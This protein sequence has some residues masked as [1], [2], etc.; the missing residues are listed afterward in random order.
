[1]CPYRSRFAASRTSF[2]SATSDARIADPTRQVLTQRAQLLPMLLADARIAPPDVKKAKT[3]KYGI[4]VSST[5]EQSNLSGGGIEPVFVDAKEVAVWHDGARKSFLG[6][7]C[8]SRAAACVSTPVGSLPRGMDAS[9]LRFKSEARDAIYSDIKPF[10]SYVSELYDKHAEAGK[11][12]VPKK[13]IPRRIGRRGGG[14]RTLDPDLYS[15]Y[16]TIKVC[17]ACLLARIS[18]L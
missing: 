2:A 6:K 14:G 8:T 1:M 10:S 3:R 18:T 9:S 15:K 11:R 12:I 17:T 4:N 13:I 5:K 16:S 7:G